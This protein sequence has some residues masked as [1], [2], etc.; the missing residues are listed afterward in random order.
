MN[1]NSIIDETDLEM[2][3]ET[4][5]TNKNSNTLKKPKVT[6][7]DILKSLNLKVKNGILEYSLAAIESRFNNEA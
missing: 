2:N 3:C 7:D 4:T 5:I 1:P 6:Y